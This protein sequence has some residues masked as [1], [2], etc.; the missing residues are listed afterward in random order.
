MGRAFIQR[1]N[2]IFLCTIEEIPAGQSREF[3]LPDGVCVAVFHTGS[4]FYAVENRCP[5]AGGTLSGGLLDQEVLM[6]IWHGWRF[7]LRTRQCL[8][9]PNAQLRAYSLLVEEE[10]LYLK[11]SQLQT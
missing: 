9:R 1:M 11:L 8:T 6:C 10:N 3:L 2:K 5:H 4:G 7:D